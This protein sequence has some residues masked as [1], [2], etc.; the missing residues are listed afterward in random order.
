MFGEVLK[1]LILNVLRHAGIHL[2]P[3]AFV[4]WLLFAE[5]LGLD[6][7][8]AAH[9]WEQKC[10]TEPQR[11]K[12]SFAWRHAF[13]AKNLEFLIDRGCWRQLLARVISDSECFGRWQIAVADLNWWTAWCLRLALL[14]TPVED[15]MALVVLPNSVGVAL[16]TT[17]HMI[18]FSFT[19]F[20]KFYSFP[21]PLYFPKF[22]SFPVPLYLKIS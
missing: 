18:W 20:L 13:C 15:L 10:M 9:G 14:S 5:L 2:V 4:M 22:D 16:T 6:A 12:S 21:V 8:A 17:I 1:L 3:N 11:P 7:R 19:T